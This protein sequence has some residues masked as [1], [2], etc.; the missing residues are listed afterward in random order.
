MDDLA[1]IIVSTNEAMVN[2]ASSVFHGGVGVLRRS[3]S[4]FSPYSMAAAS[5][6]RPPRMSEAARASV[7]RT[8]QTA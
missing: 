8:K 1:I 7:I 4:F 2:S 6:R 5:T 3:S